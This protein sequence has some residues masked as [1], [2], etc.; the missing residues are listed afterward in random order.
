MCLQLDDTSVFRHKGE[1]KV[2]SAEEDA[3]SVSDSIATES[4]ISE[5]SMETKDGDS[6]DMDTEEEGKEDG[7]V[8][9]EVAKGWSVPD[10]ASG[11][12]INLEA[13]E[14]AQGEEKEREEE[15]ENWEDAREEKEDSEEEEESL[16]PDTSIQLQHVMGG[17]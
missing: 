6:S 15:E 12:G 9:T 11:A 8:A 7:E 4:E 5:V 10:A 14:E 17:K 2:R 16:F 13:A 1:R 3:A